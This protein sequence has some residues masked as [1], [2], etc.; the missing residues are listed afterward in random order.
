MFLI[1]PCISSDFFNYSP[2]AAEVSLLYHKIEK[3]DSDLK[4]RELHLAELIDEVV[5]A[6]DHKEQAV[7]RAEAAR[8]LVIQLESLLQDML[9]YVKVIDGNVLL[10]AFLELTSVVPQEPVMNR[11]AIIHALQKLSGDN[12]ST[13]TKKL[14][15]AVREIPSETKTLAAREVFM[16]NM[17]EERVNIEG[18]ILLCGLLLDNKNELNA[19]LI[20]LGDRVR[21]ILQGK[22]CESLEGTSRSV[23][24]FKGVPYESDE[25][26]EQVRRIEEERDELRQQISVNGN[27]MELNRVLKEERKSME[28]QLLEAHQRILKEQDETREMKLQVETLEQYVEQLEHEKELFQREVKELKRDQVIRSRSHFDERRAEEEAQQMRAE[29]NSVITEHSGLRAA[30]ESQLADLNAQNKIP[31]TEKI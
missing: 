24:A 1:F 22:P 2:D 4:K 19:L 25:I 29:L 26:Q 10:P 8:Y 21:C 12:L 5:Y 18:G 17:T 7:R 23:R 27:T 13:R 15:A 20:D 16:R 6:E 3:L 11:E 14:I 28:E 30:M 9:G 31:L